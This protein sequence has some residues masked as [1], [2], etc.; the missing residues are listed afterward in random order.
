MAEETTTEETTETTEQTDSTTFVDGKYES[1]EALESAYKELQ[2][3]YSTKTAE[4]KESLGAFSGSPEEYTM[5]EGLVASDDMKTWAK[6]NKFSNEALNGFV[7]MQ[8][9]GQS[10]QL[11]EYQAGEIKKLGEN[12]QERIKN[13]SDWAKANL[14]QEFSDALNDQFIGAMSIQ[15]VEKMMELSKSSTP[16]T[17]TPST[18]V[19][20]DALDKMQ[21]EEMKDGKRRYE[22]DPEFREKVLKLR[23]QVA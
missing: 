11:E 2:S 12:A 13:A 15:A 5:D 9:E 19:D 3:S 8:S 23:E 21:F 1:A 7:K 20:K 16:V 4:Y 22:I 17:K 6:D 10:K 18:E 14:G